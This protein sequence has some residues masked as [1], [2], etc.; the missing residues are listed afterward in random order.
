M[1][2][3]LRTF[4]GRHAAAGPWQDTAPLRAELFGIERLEQHAISLA[5]AQ[6]VTS[7][8]PRVPALHLRLRDNAAVLLA[9]YRASAAE[10]ARGRSIVPAAEWLLDNYHLVE[11]QIREVRRDLPP[12]YYRQL[13]K[14]LDGPFTGYPRVFG[15]V[16]AFVS[17]TD[18]HFDPETLRR[19][20]VAYQGVQPLTIGELW[21][22]PITLRIVMIEN[23]RRL[24]DQITAAHAARV[25]ADQLVEAQPGAAAPRGWLPPGTETLDDAFSA[26]LAKRLRGRDPHT[27][28]ALDWLET[29]LE[30]QGSSIEAIVHRA[31]EREGASNVTVR[32][33]ITGMRL[34]S[35]T[36][37]A[38][39]VESVS[40]VDAR[41]R[42]GSDFAAM[43]FASRNL[44]RTAIEE[45]ARGSGMAETEVALRAVAAARAGDGRAGT[46]GW[47]LIAEGRAGLERTIGFRP[48]GRLRLRNRMRALGLRGYALAILLTSVVLVAMA[49]AAIAGPGVGV[50]W[51]ALWALAAFLPASEVATAIV[52]RVVAL[53][54]APRALPGLELKEGIPP[55][56]RTLVAVPTL[57]SDAAS[58]EEQIERLEVHH[59]SGGGGDLTFALLTDGP[60]A[61]EEEQAEDADLLALARDR[62][63]ALNR[64]Y[65]P[66]PAGPR[67]LLLHRRR[68]FSPGEG[69]WMGWERKRGKLHEL[70]RLLRGA[71]DTS[72]VLA[73]GLP[74]QIPDGVRYVITLDADT[75]MPRDTAARLIGK[76]AH[77]LNLPVFD[78]AGRR[79]VAGH[80]ILQPR[81]T[82]AIPIGDEGSLYQRTVSGP[83]G[84]D[85]YA[86]AA[87]DV[88]Q[89]LF[90][91]GSFTGKG[92]YDVDAF[93]A[94]LAGRVPQGT[95]L[96]HDLFEGIYARA[97]LASDVELVEEF[98]ARYDVAAKR[99]HRWTRGDWQV[100]PWIARARDL[101]A[102]GRW[103]LLDNLRRSLLAPATLLTLGLGWLL[104]LHAAAVATLLVLVSIL[105]PLFLPSLFAVLPGRAGV[106]LG[107]HMRA[108]AGDLRQAAMQG[109]LSITFL[110]D[111][112]R[113]MGDAIVRTLW[114]LFVTHRHLLEWTTAAQSARS[115]R[116]DLS[117]FVRSMWGS[118]ALGW[119][120]SL[121]A[122]LL[123][124]VAWPLALPFALLWIGAPVLALWI[125][126]SPKASSDTALTAEDADTLHLIAR[127]T[128]GFFE[129]FVTPEDN[130]LPPDNFQ[131]D[132][133]PVIAHR[134]SPTNI[135]LYLL[136][137]VAAR[138]FGWCGTLRSVERLEATLDT[139][140]R[141]PRHRGHL[142]NWYATQN[143][144]VLAPAYVSSVD[145]GNLAGHLI[146]LAQA[147]EEW[148]RTPMTADPRAGV[149]A[150]LRL[151]RAGIGDADPAPV[152][153]IEERMR[154]ADGFD[155]MA[156]D[157]LRLAEDAAGATESDEAA[158][159]IAAF[160]DA[161]AEHVADRRLTHERSCPDQRASGRSRRQRARHCDG[162]GVRFP[163]RPR[164]KAALDRLFRRRE[165]A[166]PE[167]LRPS[168]LGGA[169]GQPLR[170]R[171]GRYPNPPLVPTGPNRDPGRHGIGAGVLVGLDVRISHAAPGNA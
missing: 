137:A 123:A 39:L 132:P 127:R 139:L 78:A 91:E 82:P 52:N 70:N 89:D 146:V 102:V 59:L 151:A 17:H 149:A 122:V 129:T 22:V 115:P 94:A 104:P 168:G 11:A 23:L 81:V 166:R 49:L 140:R 111:Q 100:L 161:V 167:L 103:K 157:L 19:Y 2:A 85:P 67:F 114:R 152:A 34:I 51:L 3:L 154:Q 110:P 125:S 105:V 62:I 9:A 56:L 57:L 109:L 153:R 71:T 77:P 24:A 44:Y 171:Q 33:I 68:Q 30:R 145:S 134:T 163:P 64:R 144:R 147:C 74:P 148:T 58:L 29:Q 117:G 90:D 75:R 41:L 36:D 119:V 150:A 121:G 42:D 79:V 53:C 46:P 60:D 133:K 131:E 118:V 7:R 28:P 164:A 116:L 54:V 156:L 66:G 50:G 12:G 14:L 124:P 63:D 10:V 32:N 8:P 20:L 86:S 169:A 97:G 113:R 112:T 84:M 55:D 98:P 101:P 47:H 38:D 88:Y 65:G 48:S 126:R 43:D 18:S 162:D 15:L 106:Q 26:Q 96:S 135:G 35:D 6:A 92:I 83:G 143:L 107:S 21:A 76:M 31:Q 158:R 5:S 141:L 27:T 170:H 108:L 155:A 25:E 93:E 73:G 120:A 130:M 142:F 165:P 61:P 69:V 99:Q 136:S 95:L 128:W 4:G 159:W 40:L 1:S 72:F 37:W 87:S 80:A 138:D 13:P 160:R 16:W 45:L